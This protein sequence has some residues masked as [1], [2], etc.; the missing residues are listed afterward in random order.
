M[1]D[2]KPEQYKKPQEITMKYDADS[3]Y[4]KQNAEKPVSV[5]DQSINIEQDP[6]LFEKKKS[7]NSVSKSISIRQNENDSSVQNRIIT[8]INGETKII[9]EKQTCVQT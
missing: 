5:K 3:S 9:R 6:D 7:I 2:K 4:K 1:K 8:R